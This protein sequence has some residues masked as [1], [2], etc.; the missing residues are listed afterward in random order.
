MSSNGVRRRW[1]RGVT[2][3]VV[4]MAV[5]VGVAPV[6]QASPVGGTIS[7]RVTLYDGKPAVGAQ[8]CAA[9]GVDVCTTT[10]KDGRYRI[11]GLEWSNDAIHV[12]QVKVTAPGHL[13]TYYTPKGTSI[14]VPV[15]DD[16]VKMTPGATGVDLQLLKGVT[17]NGRVTSGGEASNG[18]VISATSTYGHPA[19][20]RTDADGKYSLV[21]PPG[22]TQITSST[23][24][25]YF[26]W[27]NLLGQSPELRL[28][29]GATRTVNIAVTT[30]TGVDGSTSG[31]GMSWGTCPTV[32]ARK[33]VAGGA[34]V[35]SGGLRYSR[36][37]TFGSSTWEPGTYRLTYSGWRLIAQTRTVEVKPNQL[38]QLDH[39]AL[40]SDT[41]TYS[42]V[43]AGQVVIFGT[44]VVGSQLV[45]DTGEWTPSWAIRTIQWYRDGQAIAKANVSTYQPG[46][47]DVGKRL[48][49]KVHGYAG[50][51]L[52]ADVESAPTAVVQ[53]VLTTAKPVIVGKVKVG[54][55]LTARTGE[56]GP[57]PVT[58][59]YAWFRSGKVVSGATGAKYRLTK[60]DK[61]KRITVK[62]TGSLVNYRTVV[63]A[64]AA[65]KKVVR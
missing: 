40:V 62:V 18:Q 53:G 26:E 50:E 11:T 22:V 52:E 21:V 43:V 15:W 28:S 20:V 41:A 39:V 16:L 17:I 46:A 3:V 14:D 4:A 54:K 5:G 8:V 10:G 59:T 2:G 63:R 61:G 25:I 65:T 48:T 9:N 34:E 37:C 7:G 45:A 24:L 58:L 35:P 19:I 30:G 51:G 33:I 55:T 13:T 56:W 27:R 12:Y 32:S 60:K 6:A 57:A 29:D 38:T 36:G 47:A 49:V 1:I 42:S 64:S 31:A 23:A 44:P